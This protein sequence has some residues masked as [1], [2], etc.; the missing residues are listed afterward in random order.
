MRR[1]PA[2]LVI[3]CWLTF[4]GAAHAADINVARTDD[5]DGAC[6]GTGCSL[7]QAIAFAANGDTLRLTAGKYALTRGMLVIGKPLTITGAGRQAT[8]IDGAGNQGDRIM[9]VQ[10]DVTI[11][12]LTFQ[13]AFHQND[14][15][16]SS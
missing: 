15:V 12:G 6:A 14:E 3:A 10:A 13:N 5:P 2:L 4:A 11:T 8:S 9:K 7:R 16:R 1:W